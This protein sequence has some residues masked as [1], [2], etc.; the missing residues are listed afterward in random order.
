MMRFMLETMEGMREFP[1]EVDRV[2]A[3]GYAGRDREKTLAHIREL[4]RE[5]GVPAPK[6]IPTIFQCGTNVLTQ[7]ERLDCLGEKTCGEV[8]Y[9]IVVQE[10]AIY[11]GVGSDHTD[12]ALEATD[13]PRAKQICPKPV[14]GVLWP[15]E[16]LKDHWD[17]IHLRSWQTVD[18]GET[19]YQDGTLAEILPVETILAELNER[20]G[21]MDH[22][23]IFSGT[24]PLLKGFCFGNRFRYEM[25]DAVLSRTLSG[26]Y[27]VRVMKEEQ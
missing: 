1:V 27:E 15:Y 17:S 6:R 22:C 11:I 18:G 19:A 2:F 21:D 14:S 9:V 3:I 8:E 25:H 5:L 23:V 20:V 13:V 16:E 7:E 10:G 26:A 4:E 24:V 12:R